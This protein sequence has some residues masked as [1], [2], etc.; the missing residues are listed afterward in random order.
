MKQTLLLLF[1][2]SALSLVAQPVITSQ[3]TNQIVILGGNATFNVTVSGT[4][5]FTYQ[6][7]VNGTNLPN[8]IISTAAGGPLFDGQQATNV[9]LNS[10]QGSA[11]DA[12]GNLYVADS[13]NHV[14][15]KI[16]TNG[17]CKIVAGTGSPGFSGDGGA[18][19]NA[20][21]SDPIAVVVD[22]LGNL[23]ISDRYNSKIRKVNTNGIISTLAGNLNFGPGYLSDPTGLALMTNGNLL[24]A[25]PGPDFDVNQI[26]MVQPNG[27]SNVVVNGNGFFGYN[28]DNISPL[29]ASLSAPQ[30][31]AIDA[32]GNRYIADTRN[33][34]IRKIPIATGLITTIAGT[35]ASGYSGDGAIATAAKINFAYGVAVNSNGTSVF[36][37]DSGNHAIRQITNNLISSIAGAG[38]S[39]FSGD[40]GNALSA[41][42]NLPAHVCVGAS[43]T[44][45]IA[46]QGNNRIRKINSSRIIST[47][48]GRSLP[49]GI[50]AS[51]ATLNVPAGIARDSSGNLFIA[52][53]DNARIRKINTNGIISTFAGSGLVG[54]SGDGT[55]ATNARLNQPY[56]VAADIAGNVF[57]ADTENYRLRKVNPA[58]IIST[59]AGNGSSAYSKTNNGQV[60]TNVSM[61]PYGVAV[62]TTGNVFIAEPPNCVVRK[63]AT[64]GIITLFAG[65][66]TNGF[67]GNNGIATNAL[68]YQP[69]SVYCSPSGDVFIG[70]YGAIRR[71]RTNGIVVAVAGKGYL[72]IGNTGNGG[73]ATGANIGRVTSLWGDA[74]G[75]IYF[76]DNIFRVIRKIAT[77]G[78]ISTVAGNGQSGFT[79]DNGPA[80]NASIFARAL[81]GDG[82]GN[83]FVTDSGNNRLRKISNFE[84]ANQ[85]LLTLGGVGSD[86]LSNTYSVVITDATGSV[87]SRVANVVLQSPPVVPVYDGNSLSLSWDAIASVNYQLQSATNLSAPFWEDLGAPITASSNRVSVSNL[88]LSD[89]QRFYRARVLP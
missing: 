4:G 76:C 46:D 43:N 41:L 72:Q 10:P 7:R 14:I 8:N 53:G 24:V 80:L 81:I 55:T 48:A 16:G 9:V 6:W 82:N 84:Y 66:G 71:V 73:P 75:N 32:A 45:F 62:D 33:Y 52:D 85:P 40:G 12:A 49:D 17:V 44:L 69:F 64:N 21:L 19:T 68:L 38:V 67:A 50:A 39:G 54:F 51:N 31:V 3:P 1:G 29:A 23:F 60:A 56:G 26:F 47:V 59:L 65:N 87:T 20:M 13:Y 25:N 78:I 30:G 61:Q 11:E 36:V 57:F 86:S 88:P 83:L 79:G 58:G 42:L 27:V 77:N 34:R 15:R 5:P 70:E 18:A 2:L 63:I 89:R 22:P 74:A 37:A 35:G 28:G